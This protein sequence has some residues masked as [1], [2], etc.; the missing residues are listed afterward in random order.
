MEH[1]KCASLGYMRA[2]LAN[3]I[4]GWK[5]LPE[6][7]TLVCNKHFKITSV[8]K[9]YNIGPLTLPR[10]QLPI[11]WSNHRDF[12][13]LDHFRAMERIFNPYEMV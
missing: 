8:K 13:K 7:K 12:C 6:T 10:L 9:F 5:G 11:L 4:L 1:L 3:I 2:L